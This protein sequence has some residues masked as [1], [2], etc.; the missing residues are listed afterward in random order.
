MNLQVQPLKVL[1]TRQVVLN[2]L[3]YST[4]LN[5]ATKQELDRLD[6]LAGDFKIQA[7]KSTIEAHYNG[8]RLPPD[9]WEYFKAYFNVSTFWTFWIE[10]IEG[11]EKFSIQRKSTNGLTTWLISDV[12]WEK[13]R[14]R[15]RKGLISTPKRG[16]HWD[17]VD[18]FIEDGSLVRIIKVYRRR[19]EKVELVVSF[20]DS[21]TPDGQGNIIWNK[22]WRYGHIKITKCTWAKRVHEEQKHS[23]KKGLEDIIVPA[24]IM[25]MAAHKLFSSFSLLWEALF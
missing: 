11:K 7:S 17:F 21:I 2:R 14:L 18:D 4:F 8:E 5:G 25:V 13:D 24:C 10:M 19:N 20:R 6:M 12:D 1:A 3:D 16:G 22:M 23:R 15:N 9:D